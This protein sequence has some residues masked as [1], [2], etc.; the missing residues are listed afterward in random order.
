PTRRCSGLMQLWP[1]A[2]PLAVAACSPAAMRPAGRPAE[3][4]ACSCCPA[5]GA[6]DPSPPEQAARPRTA[7]RTMARRGAYTAFDMGSGRLLDGGKEGGEVGDVLL[8]EALGLGPHRRM[9]ALAVAVRVQ[10]LGQVFGR[11]ASDLRDLEARIRI[12]VAGHAV[13]ALAGI[14]QYAA[15]LGIAGDGGRGA[16]SGLGLRLG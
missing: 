6:V 14:G 4:L 1:V 7:V 9:V 2:L 10:R 13:A 12:L 3:E 15:A 16:G 5:S 11:L 8:R